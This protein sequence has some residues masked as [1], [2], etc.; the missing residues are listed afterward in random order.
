M[1]LSKPHLIIVTGIPGA[2]K[3][4]FAEQFAKMFNAPLIS[5]DRLMNIISDTQ[6]EATSH[7]RA[8]ILQLMLSQ[9][10]Q[11]LLTKATILIDGATEA[12][13]ERHEFAKIA[14][15]SGYDVLIV[16]VQ[17]D[18]PTSRHRAVN[19]AK[20]HNGRQ[21][22]VTIEQYEKALKRFTPPNKAEKSVVISG[23]HTYVTQARSILKKLTEERSENTINVPPPSRPEKRSRHILIR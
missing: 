16:W 1:S 22:I 6:T 8:T 18:S 7:E 13:T 12:R 9:L 11:L 5:A 23:R 4:F 21:Q 3:T 14:K 15:A 20:R 19:S 2:G 10:E 17:T